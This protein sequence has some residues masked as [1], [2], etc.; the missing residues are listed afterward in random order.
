MKLFK[1]WTKIVLTLVLFAAGLGMISVMNFFG[2]EPELVSAPIPKDAEMI[3]R[4][5]SKTIW[6]K[7]AYSIIFESENYSMIDKELKKAINNKFI[8][9]TSK[10]LPV[11]LNKDVVAF[12]MHENNKNFQVAVFQLMDVTKFMKITGE[13][14]SNYSLAFHIGNSGYIIYGPKNCVPTE[15]QAI[16]KRIWSA[17]E[18]AFETLGERSDFVTI[19]SGAK[20]KKLP[21]EIGIQQSKESFT[22]SGEINGKIDFEPMKYVVRNEGLNITLACNPVELFHDASASRPELKL[23]KKMLEDTKPFDYFHERKLNGVSIDYL[24]VQVE[25]SIE[26]LPSIQ[27]MLPLAKMNAVFRFKKALSLEKVMSCFPQEVHSGKSTI[28]IHG[29]IFHLRLI[30][31]YNLFI[32]VD[33]NAVIPG[34]R[35]DF[36]CLKGNLKYLTS[37]NSS[38]FFVKAVLKNYE[39]IKVFNDFSE[40]TG[41]VNFAIQR[42]S[43]N[44]F[45]VNGVLPFKEGK[46]SINE[47]FRFFILAN[48]DL[49]EN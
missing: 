1:R 39:P 42:K 35:S 10:L 45:S 31:P 36:F 7:G 38:S 40:S 9:R 5:D 2:S 4:V 6:R 17:E 30:D 16:K 21:F 22:V 46:N 28:N 34:S 14:K 3:I 47:V 32:G 41:V 13:K 26:G 29:I 25:N 48:H 20:S 23:L 19:T 49:L 43:A 33:E 44:E 8:K 15:L 37:V 11:D 12:T 27:G 18:V 24:G